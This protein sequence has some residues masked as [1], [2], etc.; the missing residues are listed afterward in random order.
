MLAMVESLKNS[1]LILESKM[2]ELNQNK[3]SLKPGWPD[4]VWKLYLGNKSHTTQLFSRI[5]Q[6]DCSKK[7]WDKG[8]K[9]VSAYEKL[10]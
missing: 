4:S 3:I 8:A 6:N 7:T 2:A 10:F 5:L 1:D 9:L